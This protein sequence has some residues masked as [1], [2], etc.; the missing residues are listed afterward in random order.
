MIRVIGNADEFYRLRITRLD[1]TEN[2][3]FEWHDDILYREPKPDQGHEV[4]LWHVEAVRLDDPDSVA[5]LATCDA[6][7]EARDLVASISEALHEMTKSEFEAAYIDG[8]EQGD[9]GV[10]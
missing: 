7:G 9:T 6:Q 8:A 5:R 10:E 4:E 1:T 2:F 3:D